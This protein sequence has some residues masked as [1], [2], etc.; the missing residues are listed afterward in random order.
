MLHFYRAGGA[1]YNTFCSYIENNCTKPDCFK[2]ITGDVWDTLRS[3][4]NFSYAVF[5]NHVWG[6]ME[7]NSGLV[8]WNG[9]IGNN[10]FHLVRHI[11]Y[12]VRQ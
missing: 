5:E 3:V 6:S 8:T 1:L 7:N 11:F 2:G 4:L 12:I 9:L 10:I